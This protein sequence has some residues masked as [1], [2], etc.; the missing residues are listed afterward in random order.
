MSKIDISLPIGDAAAT[1]AGGG[2]LGPGGRS[3]SLLISRIVGR[4]RTLNR[5]RRLVVRVSASERVRTV[6]VVV[7]N[8]RHRLI[9][10]SRL[11]TVPAGRRR[12][13]VRLRH[14]LRRAGYRVTAT[15]RWASDGA[16]ITARRRA[17]FSR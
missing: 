17:R 3:R 7:R 12:I 1:G 13:G 14:R 4:A 15:G 9:G 5:K 8:S 6:R 2:R 11:V 10:R 16:R